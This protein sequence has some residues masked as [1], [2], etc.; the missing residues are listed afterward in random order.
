M[1]KFAKTIL[2]GRA[3]MP[4]NPR[5]RRLAPPTPEYFPT[6]GKQFYPNNSIL[7]QKIG[8]QRPPKS[9]SSSKTKKTAVTKTRSS[10]SESASS[11][12]ESEEKEKPIPKKLTTAEKKKAAEKS[13]FS[14]SDSGG[15]VVLFCFFT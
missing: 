6:L 13:I 3:V 7:F 5:A 8:K 10:S 14:D 2:T 9:S 11:M 12:S 15:Y 1:R 4:E